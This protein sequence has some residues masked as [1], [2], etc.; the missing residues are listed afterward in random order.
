MLKL[1]LFSKE[2]Y[3]KHQ[4]T[5]NDMKSWCD[6]AKIACCM[7]PLRNWAGSITVVKYITVHFCSS[8]DDG[9]T[10]DGDTSSDE[11]VQDKVGLT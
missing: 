10:D 3:E 7:Y 4:Y 1:K 5:E 8:A 11:S 9:S 2:R 6:N